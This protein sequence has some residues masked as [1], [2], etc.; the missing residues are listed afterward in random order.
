MVASV[1]QLYGQW[2]GGIRLQ[3][4]R[5]EIQKLREASDKDKEMYAQDEDNMVSSIAALMERRLSVFFG[6]KQPVSRQHSLIP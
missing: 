1:D 6:K 4:S 2:P 3:K 5:Q